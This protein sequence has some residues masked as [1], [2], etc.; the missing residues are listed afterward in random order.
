MRSLP[1]AGLGLFFFF[2]LMYCY[3][4]SSGVDVILIYYQFFILGTVIKAFVATAHC[5]CLGI[6]FVFSH[7]NLMIL[8]DFF[9]IFCTFCHLVLEIITRRMNFFGSTIFD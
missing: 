6:H 5:L 3:I 8:Q 4:S 7:G 9:A 1:A 2:F